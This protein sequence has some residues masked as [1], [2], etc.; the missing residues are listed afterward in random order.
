MMVILLT[1]VELNCSDGAWRYGDQG[2]DES[3]DD[4]GE[5]EDD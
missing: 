1:E 4:E 2:D 5:E 3:D